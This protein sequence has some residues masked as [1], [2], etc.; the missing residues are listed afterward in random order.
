MMRHSLPALTISADIACVM[1]AFAGPHRARERS[2]Y[3]VRTL[4]ELRHA[5]VL[6]WMRLDHLEVMEARTALVEAWCHHAVAAAE[7]VEM[8]ADGA[9]CRARHLGRHGAGKA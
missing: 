2:L 3:A 6:L 7:V 4:D 9:W 5:E 8:T 1:L